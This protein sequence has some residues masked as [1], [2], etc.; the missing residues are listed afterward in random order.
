MGW[1]CIFLMVVGKSGLESPLSVSR[2]YYKPNSIKEKKLSAYECRQQVRRL[3][4]E[5]RKSVE[6]N[7]R[8]SSLGCF[9]KIQILRF[10][11]PHIDSLERN[12][13]SCCQKEKCFQKCMAPL[14][15]QI[16]LWNTT[17]LSTRG[18]LLEMT[19]LPLS[20]ILD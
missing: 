13:L 17:D 1:L 15:K 4:N 5:L 19:P 11:Y 2:E 9:K 18:A 7:V 16:E 20:T 12:A 10:Y 3:A 8:E 6:K 14:V